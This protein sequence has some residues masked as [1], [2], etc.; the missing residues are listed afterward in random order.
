M[1]QTFYLKAIKKQNK[2]AIGKMAIGGPFDLVDHDGNKKTSN[3]YIGKWLLIYFGFTH[4]PDICPEEIEKLI[5]VSKIVKKINIS[6]AEVVP[7]F[8]TVDP[9][10]DDV[11]AVSKYVKGKIIAKNI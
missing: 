4:C 8:I 10:R 9:D 2:Q 6:N 3:D 5:N 7:M 1:R 11:K